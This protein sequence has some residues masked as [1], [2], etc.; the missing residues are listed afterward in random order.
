[1][2]KFSQSMNSIHA[3]N[4]ADLV[5]LFN[6]TFYASHQTRLEGGHSEPLYSPNAAENGDH[7]LA[8]RDDY[9]SSA[10]HEIAHWCEAGEHRRTLEDFGYEYV[11]S[12]IRSPEVQNQFYVWE[13]VPQA[14]ECLFTL[15]CGV[16]FY[17]SVDNFAVT[18]E[19]R[20]A[21]F[22]NVVRR[23]LR[24]WQ[25]GGLPPRAKQWIEVLQAHY[26]TPSDVIEGWLLE[27]ESECEQ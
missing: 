23:A 4:S 15:A 22:Y 20:Q 3:L 7:L 10:L 25:E 1:M 18:Y 17:V 5:T 26:K 19:E 9:F 14:L 2:K 21:F 24:Y 12:D 11:P 16:S 8:F 27:K 13:V 6:N